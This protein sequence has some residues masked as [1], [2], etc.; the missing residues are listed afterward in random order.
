M[1]QKAEPDRERPASNSGVLGPWGL[2]AKVVLWPLYGQHA[3]THL[4]PCVHPTQAYVCGLKELG[5]T[6]VSM[7]FTHEM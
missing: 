7:H 1:R 4:H 5:A 3:C 2:I 6:G